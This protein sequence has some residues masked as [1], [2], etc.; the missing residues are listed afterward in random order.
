MNTHPDIL[1]GSQA[2]VRGPKAESCRM[3]IPQAAWYRLAAVHMPVVS[4]CTLWVSPGT[5]SAQD[6]AEAWKET[7]PV[8]RGKQ[9][10]SKLGI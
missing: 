9:I 6:I 4:L 3:L 1:P 8:Q 2:D 5:P 7:V 10:Q